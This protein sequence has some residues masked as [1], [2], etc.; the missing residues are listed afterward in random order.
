MKTSFNFLITRKEGINFSKLSG[1]TNKIHINE[2]TG[3]NSY[4]GFNICH[5]VLVLFKFFKIINIKNKIENKILK[6]KGNKL[7]INILKIGEI[8]TKQNLS[9]IPRNLPNFR[10]FLFEDEAIQKKVFFK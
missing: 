2:R 5:G 10:D 3:Y 7:K 4:F 6:I 1:D 9:L 8:N